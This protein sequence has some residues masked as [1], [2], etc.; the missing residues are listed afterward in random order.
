M[1]ALLLSGREA[2]LSHF[3]AARRHCLDVPNSNEVQLTV[4]HGASRLTLQRIETFRSRDFGFHDMTLKGRFRVTTVERTIFDLAAFLERGQLRAALHSAVRADQG[5]VAR[6]WKILNANGPGH[7][8]AT[9]LRALLWELEEDREPTDSALEALTME[10]GLAT[11]RRPQLH[12]KV[13]TLDG[14]LA[15]LDFAWPERKLALEVDGW[16]YHASKDAFENDR[17]RDASLFVSGWGVL[18]FTW[19]RVAKERDAV[20]GTLM[21]ALD[22]CPVL[23]EPQQA[24]VLP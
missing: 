15:E 19:R 13:M 21:R 18:R 1:A 16:R 12:F 2:A 23:P 10:L 22:R 20:L 3:S 8:G 11:G 24:I 17:A 9:T 14:T 6:C 5:T 4:P 7:R